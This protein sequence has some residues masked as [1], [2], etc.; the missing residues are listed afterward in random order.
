MRLWT[1]LPAQSAESL[2]PINPAAMM[3]ASLLTGQAAK[4]SRNLQKA[5]AIRS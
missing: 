1:S 4:L 2:R 3:R 5:R